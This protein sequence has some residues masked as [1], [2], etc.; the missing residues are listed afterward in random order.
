MRNFKVVLGVAAVSLS[1]LSTSWVFALS[2]TAAVSTTNG[3]VIGVQSE[4]TGVQSFLG[5]PYAKPPVGDLRWKAPQ[6]ETW[7]EPFIADT[8]KPYCPQIRGG[9]SDESARE[10]CLGV[11]VWKP[12]SATPETPVPVMV[13]FHPGSFSINAGHTWMG[14]NLAAMGDVIVVSMNYRLNMLGF[15]ALEELK[16]EDADAVGSYGVLDQ[17]M[18]LKWVQDNIANFGGDPKNVTIFG[19]SS[20]GMS[21]CVHLVSPQSQGMFNKAIMQSGPCAAMHTPLDDAAKQGKEWVSKLG[22]DEAEDYLACLR[23]KTTAEIVAALPPETKVSGLTWSPPIG[24]TAL[25]DTPSTLFAQGAIKD[26]PVMFL[27]TK[28]EGMLMVNGQGK[29]GIDEAEY[30]SMVKEITGDHAD[31]I[32]AQYPATNY[33][34]PGEALAAML[35]DRDVKCPIRTDIRALSKAGNDSYMSYF[36]SGRNIEGFK[37]LG[38]FHTVEIDFVFFTDEGG[39]GLSE[40]EKVLSRAMV[41]QWASFAH[42]GNPNADAAGVAWPK[43][44]AKKEKYIEF[45]KRKI[46][47]TPNMFPECD[48]WDK[49]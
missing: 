39:F 29:L 16:A 1:L 42:T 4:D 23:G 44:N 6:P 47:A 5:I 32:L 28:D 13:W 7:T 21:V 49:L 30:A 48:F 12:A 41:S 35:T 9:K 8:V 36:T 19:E 11:N 31:K 38:A 33:P 26:M 25:P 24:T 40:R 46:K 18:V 14:E 2:K 45:N 3:E 43:F 20:G 22:C 37:H 17:Q 15:L 27:A 34:S 10:D